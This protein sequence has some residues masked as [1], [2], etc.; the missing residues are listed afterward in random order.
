MSNLIDITG[1]QFGRLTVISRVENNKF[2]QVMWDCVC[3][4]GKRTTVSGGHLKIGQTKSCGC[5][6]K[7]LLSKAKK[8][9]GQTGNKTYKSW[10][11]MRERCYNP[12]NKIYKYYGGRGITICKRWDKFENFYS[13][14]GDR[15]ERMSIERT[16]NNKGYSP[17]NCKWAT[18][19]EQVRNTRS[20]QLI[21]YHGKTQCMSAW[22]EEL[23]IAYKTLWARLQ[24]Y[25]P[26][27]A[28]NM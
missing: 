5:L 19:K 23:G 21:R 27:K 14:M 12:N 7:E 8:I 17:D 25:S 16:N 4:C 9:H 13:D 6:Q 22:A 18:Q 28:F 1:K 3:T 20:N 11:G 10:S 24:K 2:G 15:P 26:P